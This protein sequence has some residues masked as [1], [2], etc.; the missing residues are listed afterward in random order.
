VAVGD[1]S[2]DAT[3][4]YV[5]AGSGA[6]STAT[7]T[8][9][10]PGANTATSVVTI[11]SN[12]VTTTLVYTDSSF[13]NID[14]AVA[15]TSGATGNI[16]IFGTN[17]VSGSTVY[18]A[19]QASA[20]VNVVSINEIQARVPAL[21]AGTYSNL[22]IVSPTGSAILSNLT[23]RIVN[24]PLF[25]TSN[26]LIL[27]ANTASSTTIAAINATSY[28]IPAGSLPANVS[29]NTTTGVLS[30]NIIV[31]STA[32]WNFNVTAIGTA[33]NTVQ[34]CYLVFN[35]TPVTV[36]YLVVG[37]GGGTGFVSP[38]AGSTNHGSGGA[39]G[40]ITG[41]TILDS[42]E[43]Y[44]VG[45]G[46]ASSLQINGTDSWINCPTNPGFGNIAGFGGGRGGQ[47]GPPAPVPSRAGS[48]GGSGGGNAA[49]ANS[50][51]FPAGTGLGGIGIAGSTIYGNPGGQSSPTTGGGGGGAGRA[52]P[53]T[54]PTGV[55]F[56]GLGVYHGITGTNILYAR[57]GGDSLAD[58][59]TL[60][61]NTAT[62]APLAT[63]GTGFGATTELN[64]GDMAPGTW[65]GL[66]AT[67]GV[68]VVSYISQS[69]LATGGTVST[70]T[71]G[72]NKYYVHKFTNN[73]VP[74][75]TLTI[76]AGG[77]FPIWAN[78]NVALFSSYAG[79]SGSVSTQLRAYNAASYTIAAGNTLPTGLSLSTTGLLSGAATEE[80]AGFY[81]DAT[82]PTGGVSS[83]PFSLTLSYPTPVWVTA[84]VL[85]SAASVVSGVSVQ[86]V[87]TVTAGSVTY[88]VSPGN[89]LPSGL[90]LSSTGLL[91]GVANS[92]GSY[93]F[94]LRAAHASK[95]I[96]YSE[97]Q[98]SLLIS[99]SQTVNF[100]VVAGGGSGGIAD[101]RSVGAG[102]G[103]GA[104][105]VLTGTASLL[106]GSVCSITVGTGGNPA[107]QFQN[108]P[109]NNPGQPGT[110]SVL[111]NPGI[112]TQSATGGG[113][114]A[115]IGF[116]GA[117]GGS[118][119]GNY[120]T[121]ILATGS[122]GPGIAGTQGYPGGGS[123]SYTGGGGGASSAGTPSN[124]FSGD[125][126]IG[127]GGAGY[128]WAFTGNTYSQGGSGGSS[129]GP[130]DPLFLSTGPG[131]GNGG[132]GGSPFQSQ[133]GA[134]QAGNPGV[135]ILAVPAPRYPGSAPGA[136]VSNPPAA[137]GYTVL[138]YTAPGTYTI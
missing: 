117:T 23:I 22:M 87:A 88:S 54:T 16:R 129:A 33:A 63:P 67:P 102:G 60:N 122:P 78:A 31:N 103:G 56:A 134:G 121:T 61:G 5:L 77:R 124:P 11:S 19:G 69:Q 41:N 15:T 7:F 25:T 110:N 46:S 9:L 94:Y 12:P 132:N 42:T 24:T 114:G 111:G 32:A 2:T 128:T 90:S 81:I 116:Q 62:W 35:G 21:T 118:A 3:N 34:N 8:Q 58:D 17:F 106:A 96:Y 98:F 135:V 55:G 57:G 71:S 93:S 79:L 127:R 115:T 104:G 76:T 119:G 43:T 109:F 85:P 37:A 107:P 53:D 47:S 123:P 125:L 131:Y 50:I 86:L 27:T 84:N 70:Y 89:T 92:N 120:N 13:A 59:I 80:R 133:A 95:T 136:V 137:P 1:T 73:A 64:G 82:S 112:A 74:T 26:T 40:M 36:S 100:L 45:V 101:N 39:G 52:A 29:F 4:D 113:Q 130:G 48:S 105:G 75:S 49:G 44:Q 6:V 20:Y 51:G 14:G 72:A 83:Q 38:V 18:I 108:S 91:D 65:T 28:S 66:P 97:R 138:T 126:P 30:G 68:V 10:V 99:N